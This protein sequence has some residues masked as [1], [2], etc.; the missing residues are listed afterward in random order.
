[1]ALVTC[2]K[3]GEQISDKAKTCVHCGAVLVEEEKKH[4]VDC[5][6]E[7][8]PGATVCPSCGCPVGES[9]TEENAPQQVE[10]TGVRMTAKTK[11][12]IVIAVVTAVIIAIA[13]VI[14]VQVHK[15]KLAEQAAA[16]AAQAAAEAEELREEYVANYSLATYT[17][18]AGARS[19]ETC[20]NLIKSVWYNRVFKEMDSTTDEYTRPNGYWVSDFNEALSNLF[21]D[22]NFS[23]DISGIEENADTVA[24]FMKELKNPPEG[25]ED[26]YE[27]I[28]DMYDAYL[29]F[30]NLIT[31]PSGNLT[32][33]SSN[34][35]DADSAMATKY[36]AVELYLED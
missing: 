13:A 14:G 24:D 30:T 18:M 26:A 12:I 8:E 32:T 27:A 5:G 34:F 33:F 22:A 7:L 23:E 35:S 29:T 16:E 9:N 15:K 6:A 2:P 19:A 28:S 17:M 3:C 4:C 10:V 21:S 11:K 31:N 1:M 36:N 20:G 25:Y